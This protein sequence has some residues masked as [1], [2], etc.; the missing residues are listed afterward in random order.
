MSFSILHIDDQHTWGGGQVQVLSLLKGLRES[1]YRAELVTQPGSILGKRA[2]DAGLMVHSM[3]MRGDADVFCARRISN[4]IRSD[5]FDIVHM[6]TG[7]AHMVGAMACAFNPSPACVVTK[8]VAFPINKGPLGIARLKYFWRIDTYIAISDAVKNVLIAAGVRP[9]KIHV[10]YSGV[11]PP[12]TESGVTVAEDIGVGAERKLIGNIGALVEAKGQ[13]Y[14]LEAAPLILKQVPEAR[15]VIVGD[16][17]LKSKL[18]HL[19]SRLGVSDA[20]RFVGFQ[21]NVG[22]FLAAFDVLVLPSLMEGL[23]NSAIEAMMV[24]IPVVGTKVG[25]LPEVIDHGRTGLLVPPEDHVALAE[26][27]LEVLSNPEKAA[28]FGSAGRDVAY[29]RFTVSRMVSGTI[30]V[31]EKVLKE[32]CRI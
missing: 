17:R 8:R 2:K 9:S 30:G 10:V 21:E 29:K 19:A 25:G 11:V 4:I 5:D 23:N 18:K 1:S 26:A 16:G 24:G 6:H 27:V 12:D 3:R 7:H 28:A 32:R 13:R 31:Y 20:V 15:F 22:R 14:L